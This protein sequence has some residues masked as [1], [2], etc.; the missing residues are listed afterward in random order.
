MLPRYTTT[1]PSVGVV[2]EHLP[3]A[4]EDLHLHERRAVDGDEEDQPGEQ[5]LAFW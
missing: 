2:D 4:G 3:V 5:A 1:F